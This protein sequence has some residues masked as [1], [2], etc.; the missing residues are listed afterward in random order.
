MEGG[1]AFFL[2][3]YLLAAT[4]FLAG[5]SEINDGSAI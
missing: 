5:F 1:A 2:I 4:T 3:G